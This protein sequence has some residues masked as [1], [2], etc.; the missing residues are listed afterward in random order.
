[1]FNAS[2]C[3]SLHAFTVQSYEK[4]QRQDQKCMVTTKRGRWPVGCV[5]SFV[6]Y[7]VKTRI[8][9]AMHATM[10]AS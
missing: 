1:M 7:F 4:R 10:L 5:A 9:H 8:I 2:K 6:K 3:I